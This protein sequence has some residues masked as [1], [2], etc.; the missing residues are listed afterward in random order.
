MDATSTHRRIW[1]GGLTAAGL[2]ISHKVGYAVAHRSEAARIE[3]LQETGHSYLPVLWTAALLLGGMAIV[4]FAAQRWD[5][6][7]TPA[8]WW[9][10]ALA[11]LAL[12]AGGFLSIELAER[13]LSGHSVGLEGSPV[14]IALV[15][16]ALFA[17]IAV[18]VLKVIGRAVDL[19]RERLARPPAQAG[20]ALAS[21]L[22]E[23]ED[24]LRP[25]A[26]LGGVGLRAPP[27]AA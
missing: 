2:A 9:R 18:I 24:L 22:H 11:L 13:W 21:P 15:V 16:Q 12:Q 1:L 10:T 17:V 27:V 23:A 4:A 7:D 20:T 3:L 26:V 6:G 5:R 25:I 14:P 19:V 8:S